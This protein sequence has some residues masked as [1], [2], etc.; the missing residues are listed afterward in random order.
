[1]RI[2]FVV[3]TLAFAAEAIKLNIHTV[4]DADADMPAFMKPYVGKGKALVEKAKKEAANVYKD[5]PK[6]TTDEKIKAMNDS[7]TTGI[8]ANACYDTMDPTKCLAAAK[9]GIAMVRGGWSFLKEGLKNR[10][11][12]QAKE[13]AIADHIASH[14]GV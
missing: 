6:S 14:H 9:G 10:K 13:K 5:L 7:A 11:A 8:A 1:M 12:R 4:A 2:A 3:C